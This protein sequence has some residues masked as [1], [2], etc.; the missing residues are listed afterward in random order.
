MNAIVTNAGP[1]RASRDFA[2]KSR[3]GPVAIGV[4]VAFHGLVGY[5]LVNGLGK[6]VIEMVKKPLEAT[7]VQEVKLPPP[8]PPP[9]P[10]KQIVKQE[11]PK[12]QAPPPPAY[13]PPPDV[14][15]PAVEAAPAITAVQTT[16]AVAPP[17]AAP[18]PVVAEA[19]P[20]PPAPI[21][22]KV[23]CPRQVAPV[24]PQRAIDEGIG[25]T[26]VA[27]ATIRDG[28]VVD[29]KVL[30]G[31]RALHAAVRA[32]MLQYRCESRGEVTAKQTFEFRVE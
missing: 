15:P 19:T 31:P 28:A 7:I 29:I 11:L 8:P 2:P 6:Q 27:Q 22:I 26:V 30:S 23:A 24:V 1:G 32:A 9:P 17:P 12:P 18:P 25:G 10:P 21:D 4:M 16:T 13:V 20:A 5:A 14:P 3:F